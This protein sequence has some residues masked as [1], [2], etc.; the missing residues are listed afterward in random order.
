MIEGLILLTELVVMLLLLRNVL[1]AG[2]TPEEEDLGL[3]GFRRR[4]DTSS[5]P[6][7][8][9]RSPKKGPPGA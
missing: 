9:E 4:P 8:V 1:R 3:F 2:Q 6:N 7:P 5:A